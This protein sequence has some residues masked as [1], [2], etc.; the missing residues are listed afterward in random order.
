MK[1]C[2]RNLVGGVLTSAD[3]D[4]PPS[5]TRRLKRVLRFARHFAAVLL[6]AG[7]VQRRVHL[8]RLAALRDDMRR[9]CSLLAVLPTATKQT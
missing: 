4:V 7:P 1:N 9:R 6:A 3:G 5:L 8:D 2:G